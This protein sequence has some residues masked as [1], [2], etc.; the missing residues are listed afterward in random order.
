MTTLDRVERWNN[1]REIFFQK[2]RPAMEGEINILTS[3]DFMQIGTS[4]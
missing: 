2:K 3:Q 1:N 4:L